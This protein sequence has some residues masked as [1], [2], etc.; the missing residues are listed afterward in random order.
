MVRKLEEQI[1][2]VENRKSKSSGGATSSFT[3]LFGMTTPTVV[4]SA[5]AEVN[6]PPAAPLTIARGTARDK[7]A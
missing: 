4:E 7:V 6:Y 3:S 2:V 5:F 1:E